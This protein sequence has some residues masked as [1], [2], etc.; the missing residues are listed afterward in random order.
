[1]NTYLLAFAGSALLSLFLTRLIRDAAIRIG[2][3]DRP[4][5]LRKLHAKPIPPVGGVAIVVAM[6]AGLA[7]AAATPTLVGQQLRAEAPRLVAL[8]GLAFAMMLV[9][10]WDDV[11]GLAPQLK[12]GLQI[13]IASVAWLAGVQI[14][15]WDA[16]GVHFGF[17]SLPITV[18]WIVA[19]T[20]AF[21]LLDGV[22]GLAAGAALFATMALLIVS[23]TTGNLVVAA[24]LSALAGASAGFLRYNFNPASIFL[25]DSGSLLLGF[26][27]SVLSIES[28]EKSTIAFAI[29]VPIVSL[30][31]PVLDTAVVV[32]RRLIS[33]QPLFRADRRHIHHMLLDRGMSPRDVVMLLY[34]VCGL[35]G[36]LSLLIANPSG[37]AVGPV[38]AMLGIAAGIG[39]Q[40]LHIPELRALN[41]H[42]VR[43][44]RRQSRLLAGGALVHALVDA[45]SDASNAQQLL[46]ALANSLDRA[47]FVRARL[48]IPRATDLESIATGWNDCRT[49]S[50]RPVSRTLEWT[51]PT[52]G[53][54]VSVVTLVVPLSASDD[55]GKLALVAR[56][57]DPHHAAM[58]SWLASDI[59]HLVGTHLARVCAGEA[60][61]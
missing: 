41:S 11:A 18:L 58:I 55:V 22:D 53:G 10:L 4:D 60:R 43:G 12:F 17:L 50:S 51:S 47:G 8:S 15:G 54:T 35:L 44:V 37:R 31:L 16:A 49:N 27:L 2:W 38:L 19:I 40:Q 34:A 3:V 13:L 30:G 28:S 1:V 33:R 36:L 5:G 45:L 25:G 23:I 9:G 57:D 52:N 7:I 24:I 46:R 29:A 26:T 32:L 48:T 61:C 59:G 21:N 42:V 6:A 56:S 14:A 20:N 39:I